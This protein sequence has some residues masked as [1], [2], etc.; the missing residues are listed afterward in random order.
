MQQAGGPTPQTAPPVQQAPP[1]STPTKED[2]LHL[3]DIPD[4]VNAVPLAQQILREGQ[5]SDAIFGN[6]VLAICN[7]KSGSS[8]KAVTYLFAAKQAGFKDFD[9]LDQEPYFNEIR[10]HPDFVQLRNQIQ[11][12]VMAKE[13]WRKLPQAQIDD[14]M[15]IFDQYDLDG[16][17]KIDAKEF[18]VL[19]ARTRPDQ[20]ATS[21]QIFHSLDL[22]GSGQITLDEYL[23]YIAD[24][25]KK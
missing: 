8:E 16:S 19:I 1:Q 23:N 13:R 14:I 2:I 6:Y 20:A 9:Q 10:N 5:G 25:N 4:F 7:A 17:G 15:K 22:D 21:G 12:E 11:Q 18:E 3:L 24:Q